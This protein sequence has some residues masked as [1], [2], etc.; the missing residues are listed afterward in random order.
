MSYSCCFPTVWTGNF[1]KE[2]T[3]IKIP[4]GRFTLPAVLYHVVLLH[5]RL[6]QHPGGT[7]HFP[8]TPARKASPISQ[9][10][11]TRKD[12]LTASLPA[13][14]CK[15]QIPLVPTVENGNASFQPHALGQ[16]NRYYLH[17]HPSAA[18]MRA[19]WTSPSHTRQL[20]AA[21]KRKWH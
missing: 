7:S 3:E 13:Q 4:R 16:R 1:P 15:H 17:H 8:G 18:R 14:S 2:V 12:G 11:P 9:I 20:Q 5:L 21:L 6:Q 10:L 19:S